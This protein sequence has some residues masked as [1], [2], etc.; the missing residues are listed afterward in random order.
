MLRREQG[1]IP[2]IG[3]F[4]LGPPCTGYA[5]GRILR[6]YARENAHT[7]RQELDPIP[8][9]LCFAWQLRAGPGAVRPLGTPHPSMLYAHSLQILYGC[10]KV[11]LYGHIINI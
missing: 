2:S 5:P 6:V 9:Y 11:Y 4:G 3:Q 10:F 8:S 1:S 7:L